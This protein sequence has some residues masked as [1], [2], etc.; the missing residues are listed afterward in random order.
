MSTVCASP[1]SERTRDSIE[2]TGRDKR[3]GSSVS[4]LCCNVS[5]SL[6]SPGA[7][8]SNVV[9]VGSTATDRGCSGGQALEAGP[10]NV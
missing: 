1:S 2:Y 5:V 6:A 10:R 7:A 9:R 3:T 4:M 8:I